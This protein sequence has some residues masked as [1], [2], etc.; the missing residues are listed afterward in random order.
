M[1][2]LRKEQDAD[3]QAFGVKFDVYYLESSLYTEGKVAEVVESWKKSGK[4]YEEESKN[5]P[6][7][8]STG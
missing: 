5:L 3:L 6:N 8:V 1:A 7:V 2:Y 4:S